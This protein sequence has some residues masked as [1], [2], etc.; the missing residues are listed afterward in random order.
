[1]QVYSGILNNFFN[2]KN[3]VLSVSHISDGFKNL[4]K[5]LPGQELSDPAKLL[6]DIIARLPSLRQTFRRIQ[7]LS[8]DEKH[9]EMDQEQRSSAREAIHQISIISEFLQY[10]AN[11]THSQAI[12]LE[13]KHLP[14]KQLHDASIQA[15]N[16][17]YGPGNEG[18][19]SVKGS[20]QSSFQ[21]IA[22][23]NTR[24]QEGDFHLNK[25]LEAI[26]PAVKR[27][28]AEISVQSPEELQV[29]SSI[30]FQYLI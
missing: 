15:C 17:V 3:A 18:L 14:E 23:I 20:I 19:A 5:V 12:N 16:K 30:F 10:W 8:P 21:C 11:T 22:K 7:R 2:P 29:R 1:M 27:R 25:A 9:G 26:E 4:L 6:T 13:Q 28:A 24:L